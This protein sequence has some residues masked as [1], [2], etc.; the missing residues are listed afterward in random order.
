MAISKLCT[1][2]GCGKR[3]YAHDLC[4]NHYGRQ[5]RHGSPFGGRVSP[6]S[7]MDW[8]LAHQDFTGD[9]CL[10]WPFADDGKGY[11]VVKVDGRQQYA[12]R[13]MCT[14]VNGEPPTDLHETAHSCGNGHLGCVHPGHVRWATRAENHADKLGHGTHARGERCPT[15]KI[16]EDQARQILALKDKMLKKD[17]AAMFGVTLGHVSNIH[18]GKRWGW[19]QEDVRA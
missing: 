18:L 11:G 15:V 4:E 1:I 6:G 12:H 7:L 9:E 19:L 14:L 13:I 5:R 10:K 2:P 17:I 8:L 16:T 3:Q